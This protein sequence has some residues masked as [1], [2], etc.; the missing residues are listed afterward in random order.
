MTRKYIKLFH[1]HRNTRGFTL[2]ELLVVISIISLLLAVLLPALGKARSMAKRIAC[3]GN[4]KQLATAWHMYLDDNEGYFYQG[5]NYN[6]TFGGWKG[7]GSIVERPLNK[8]LGL[9][10]EIE[11]GRNAEVF[12]CPADKGGTYDEKA[13]NYHGNS[14]QTNLMLIGQDALSTSNVPDTIEE[15]NRAIN[16]HLNRLKRD[17]I[18]HPSRVLLVGDNN[19]I[20]QWEPVGPCEMDWHDR[21]HYNNLAFLDGRVE[22]IKILKGLY[23]APQ[24]N[25]LPFRQ[26]IGLAWDL[27]EEVSCNCK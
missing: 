2:I 9:P 27:Q 7:W 13:Y 8:Y 20:N 6:H 11:T 25:V 4:L 17:S 26:I 5:F 18:S 14:Y 23:V 24:Y 12:L 15:I 21:T 22:F 10:L 3:Q 1:W 19:W 16:I